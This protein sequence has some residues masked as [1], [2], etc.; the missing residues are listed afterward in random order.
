MASIVEKEEK[1][2]TNRP[3]VAWIFINRLDANMS[4]WADITLCYGLKQPYETCTPKLIAQKVGDKSNIYNTRQNP[5]LTPQ[6][7]ANP[8]A[9]SVSAVLN[10]AHTDYYFYL[11]DNNWTIHYW[12]TNEEHVANKNMYLK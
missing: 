11:H 2:N 7:I 9:D 4:I 6:P 1:S 12:R 8:S 10:Y 5:G 3:I